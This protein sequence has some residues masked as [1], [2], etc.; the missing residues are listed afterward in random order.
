M[1]KLL[2][3]HGV[4]WCD[5]SR[6][7]TKQLMNRG[8][9]V[10]D[11]LNYTRDQE[12]KEE[13]GNSTKDEYQCRPLETNIQRLFAFGIHNHHLCSIYFSAQHIRT[14]HEWIYDDGLSAA[15]IEV[16]ATVC[17]ADG[18]KQDC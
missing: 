17:A 6:R 12:Q 3:P 8:K 15:M 14:A 2:L 11:I 7:T 9:N 13:A 5:F 16:G 4:V 18:V 10:P 1:T